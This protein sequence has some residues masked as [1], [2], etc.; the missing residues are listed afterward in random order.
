M[1]YNVT[2]LYQQQQWS[3]DGL[4]FAYV[5]HVSDQASTNIF[6]V[7]SDLPATWDRDIM[8]TDYTEPEYDPVWSPDGQSI[9]FVANHTGND[10][11]WLM[12]QDGGNQRQLTFNDFAWINILLTGWPADRLYS[13]RSGGRQVWV[14]RIDGSAQTNL[15]NNTAEE[16][17]PIWIR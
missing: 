2:Q 16:W 5:E 9:A 1:I 10:E 7:R 6:K 17:D 3:P 14:M 15:S 13:N 12:N 11:I 8:L 4:Q